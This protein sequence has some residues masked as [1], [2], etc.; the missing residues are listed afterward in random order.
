MKQ[1][2][3]KLSAL[4]LFILAGSLIFINRGQAQQQQP[5]Q[6]DKPV[7]QTRKNIRVLNGLPDSQLIPVMQFISS[8][9]G[10]ECVYCH[11]P[12]QFEKDDKPTKNTARQM[13]QMQMAINKDNKAIFGDTGAIT[14]YTCHRGQTEPQ[15]M[16]KLPH[17]EQAA[18]GGEAGAAKQAAEPLPTVDQVLAKYA[19]A[20]GGEAALRKVTS[21]VMIG[22]QTG[23]DGT[24]IPVETYRV[25]PDKIYSV[26]TGKQ[27]AM[28]SGY[29]GTVGWQKGPRGQG[30]M[31]GAQLEAIKQTADFY[32]DLKLK[33]H[34]PN[35][36]IVGRERIGGRETYVLVSKPSP[37][38]TQKLYFDTQTGLLVRVLDLLHTMIADIPSQLD[39]EDYREV[40][41]VKLPFVIRYSAVEADRSWT[42]RFTEIKNNVPVDEA[43]FNPPPAP[44]PAATPTSTPK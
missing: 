16:P 39:Y 24:S 37:N 6:G 13:I 29:N 25:A 1:I 27:G 42:R 10:V 22:T 18:G 36:S 44:A 7:E 38:T 19:Q 15:V 12:P 3:L 14:C 2:T 33:E 17:P 28:M 41:G 43:K 11:V 5:P 4:V 35:L 20:M 30:L 23:G 8:S 40:D 31:R 26:M 32:G 21:R 34:Y 9:L